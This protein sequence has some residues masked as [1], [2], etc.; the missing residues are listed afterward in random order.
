[1]TT[2]QRASA[3]ALF[4]LLPCVPALAA[5]PAPHPAAKKPIVLPTPH[6]PKV[7]LHTE[8]VVEVNKL[9]QVVRVKSGKSCPNLTFNAQTYG[10]VLQ[11]WIRHPDGTAEVGLYKVTYDYDPHGATVTRRVELL[12]AGGNWGSM[13]GAANQMVDEAHQE[14]RKKH[15]ALPGLKSILK[16]TPTPGPHR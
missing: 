7:K 5:T 12:K 10:N 3:L 1:M 14:D 13:R 16:A 9:G 2:L 8:F 11:T 6:L 4:L 15:P